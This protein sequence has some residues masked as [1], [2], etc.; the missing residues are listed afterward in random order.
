MCG[1]INKK[2]NWCKKRK[3]DVWTIRIWCKHYNKNICEKCY[4]DMY[5]RKRSN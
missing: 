5:H 2:C 3:E 1:F 4:D